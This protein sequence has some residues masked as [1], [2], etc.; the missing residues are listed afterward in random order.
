MRIRLHSTTNRPNS[1]SCGVSDYG[2]VE[3]YTVVIGDGNCDNELTLASPGDDISS[4]THLIEVNETLIAKNKITGGIVTY[5]AGVSVQLDTLFKVDLGA[6]LTIK[7]DG[8]NGN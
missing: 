7:I 1:T 3:D 5:D 2:E 8:C 6:T 4:G